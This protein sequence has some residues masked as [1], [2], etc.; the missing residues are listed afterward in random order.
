MLEEIVKAVI[1]AG[2]ILAQR[3]AQSG[4]MPRTAA[5]NARLSGVG[6]SGLTC[7]VGASFTAGGARINWRKLVGSR[8]IV[9]L[10]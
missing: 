7:A 9:A 1:G 2:S 5:G 3:M 4:G 8:K 6:H 10:R